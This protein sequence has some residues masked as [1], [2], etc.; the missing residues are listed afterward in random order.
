[1]GGV[2]SRLRP[3]LFIFRDKQGKLAG[4]IGTHVDDPIGAG[5]FEEVMSVFE[6]MKGYVLLKLRPPLSKTE[7][8]SEQQP[9]P[10]LIPNEQPGDHRFG[11][12]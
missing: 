7:P 2:K 3:A 8:L 4:L 6:E 12:R 11:H 1:M 10:Q 9:M 5:K